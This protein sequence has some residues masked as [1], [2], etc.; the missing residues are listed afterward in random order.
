MS[1]ALLYLWKYRRSEM[2]MLLLLDELQPRDAARALPAGFSR[3]ASATLQHLKDRL[4]EKDPAIDL[5]EFVSPDLTV[6][7]LLLKNC[8][9]CLD[10]AERALHPPQPT[11]TDAQE[12]PPTPI[13]S[14]HE[15]TEPKSLD[16]EDPVV[17]DECLEAIVDESDLA[18]TD[19]DSFYDEWDF[20]GR[21]ITKAEVSSV[22]CVF[23]AS[24]GSLGWQLFSHCIDYLITV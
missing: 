21:P 13:A 22:A 10:E 15:A 14:T 7:R 18:P 1:E 19:L 20:S 16:S 3:P 23:D 2:L 17:D 11:T 8:Q 4:A 9:L 5:E 24:M 12:V 6:M